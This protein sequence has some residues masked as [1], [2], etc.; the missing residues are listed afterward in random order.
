MLALTSL[1]RSRLLPDYPT[2]AESGL[3][4]FEVISWNGLVAPAGTPRDIVQRMNAALHAA[5][6]DPAFVD[7]LAK[8]GATPLTDTPE[9]MA[10]LIRK[11]L[12][13]WR[14]VAQQN[15]IKAD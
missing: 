14:E 12:V 11:E 6:A 13:R 8:L 3:P 10:A 9:E 7:T 2:I 4:G 1:E 15:G 5:D